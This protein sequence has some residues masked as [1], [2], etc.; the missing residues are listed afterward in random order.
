MQVADERPL[1]WPRQ[2]L[3]PLQ[4]SCVAFPVSV[5]LLLLSVRVHTV[6]PCLLP[7]CVAKDAAV[8]NF[9]SALSIPQACS[10]V[11]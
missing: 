5:L 8:F 11:Q 7:S 2:L 9:S 1:L 3:V 10:R 6:S 4:P